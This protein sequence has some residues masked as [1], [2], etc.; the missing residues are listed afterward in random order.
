MINKQGTALIKGP[1]PRICMVQLNPLQAKFNSQ[2]SQFPIY[3]NV[4][5]NEEEYFKQRNKTFFRNFSNLHH[6]NLDLKYRLFNLIN[7][8]RNLKQIILKLEQQILKD[9]K[10]TEEKIDTNII[11]DNNKSTIVTKIIDNY[12]KRK[13][14][15]RKKSELVT[16]HYCN[17]PNCNKSYPSKGSLKMHIKLK[18]QSYLKDVNK[19][20]EN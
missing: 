18:H 19:L 14:K 13:R 20:K 12:I 3:D 16:L 8:K 5:G 2:L 10:K 9:T 1:F 7:E 17:Y 4:I 11:N 15:R 6:I